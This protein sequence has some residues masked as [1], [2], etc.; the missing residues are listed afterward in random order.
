M[1][2]EFM[3]DHIA[4]KITTLTDEQLRLLYMLLLTF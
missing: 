1:G 2:R 3:I 4:S